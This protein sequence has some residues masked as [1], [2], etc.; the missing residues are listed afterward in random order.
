MNNHLSENEKLVL[1]YFK[2]Q[3][4]KRKT[5][6]LSTIEPKFEIKIIEDIPSLLQEKGYIEINKNNLGSELEMISI[7]LKDKFFEY[8]SLY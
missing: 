5:N 1:N 6:P 4:D 7:T 2:E 8:F 3:Y